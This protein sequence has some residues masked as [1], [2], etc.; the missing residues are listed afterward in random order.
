MAGYMT[1]RDAYHHLRLMKR[2]RHAL[3]SRDPSPRKGGRVGSELMQTAELGVG[4]LVASAAMSY[5]GRPSLFR[6]P[7]DLLGGGALLAAGLWMKP[8]NKLAPHAINL[9]N[10]AIMSFITQFGLGLGISLPGATQ[11]AGVSVGQ[12]GS[13]QS[14]VQPEELAAAIHA[15]R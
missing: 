9:G 15:V 1:R 7:Y 3:S 10:G 6:V 8:N 13:G 5:F 12:I 2:A 14:F 4:A 11:F